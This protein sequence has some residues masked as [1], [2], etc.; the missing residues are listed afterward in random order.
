LSRT[1]RFAATASGPAQPAFKFGKSREFNLRGIQANGLAARLLSE[2]IELLKK[3]TTNEFPFAKS[4]F[5]QHQFAAL[6][7]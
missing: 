5:S 6:G 3:V 1:R 7:H 4:M 2:Y